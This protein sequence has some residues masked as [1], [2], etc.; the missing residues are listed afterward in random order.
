MRERSCDNELRRDHPG[1]DKMEVFA[2]RWQKQRASDPSVK[3][4]KAYNNYN[5]FRTGSSEPRKRETGWNP[6]DHP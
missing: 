4:S 3:I 6:R 2:N 1:K 5:M